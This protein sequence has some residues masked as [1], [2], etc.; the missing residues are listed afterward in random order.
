MSLPELIE[1][2]RADFVTIDTIGMPGQRTFYLQAAQE[3]TIITL[4]IEKEQAAALSIAIQTVLEQQGAS[5]TPVETPDMNLIHPIEALFRVGGLRLNYDRVEQM[6]VIIAEE[7]TEEAHS[8][9]V[10]IWI[11]HSL[12]AALARQAAIT[13]AAGRPIC[14]LCN[15]P[16]NPGEEHVCVKGNGRKHLM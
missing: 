11:D 14:P 2:R 4:I 13:V 16:I 1:L 5:G 6:L 12:M 10:R 8:S 7:L 9:R 3:K 15:E